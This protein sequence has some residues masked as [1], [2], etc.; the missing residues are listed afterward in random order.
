MSGQ[1][2]GVA[3]QIRQEE[4]RALYTHCYGHSLNLAMS[5]TIKGVKLMRNAMDV[6]HEIGKFIKYSPKRNA[7]FDK[8]KD[9]ICPDQ[10]GFRVLCPTRWTVRAKSLKSVLDNY[11]VMQEL[12]TSVL[13]G[14][15]DSD[16]RARVISVKA[17]MESFNFFFGVSLGQLVL[18]LTDNLSATL[19]SSHISATEGL[20]KWQSSQL[21]L[22]Q[23]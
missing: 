1:R 23:R 2:S 13:D 3:T 18:N 14:N 19:Q 15:I 20:K 17:Q 10:P 11:G 12:W 9:E 7:E 22:C 5:D 21:K 16:V 8:I 6:T 4:P